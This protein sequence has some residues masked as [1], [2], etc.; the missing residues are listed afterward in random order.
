MRNFL[1]QLILSIFA[2]VKNGALQY[3]TPWEKLA[4]FIALCFLSSL[5]FGLLG[6]SMA[7]PLFGVDVYNYNDLTN[8]GDKDSIRTVKMLNFLFHIGT[9]ILPSIL[10]A[11]LGAFE[12]SDYL[13]T[14]KPPQRTSILIILFTRF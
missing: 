4:L 2:I 13:L 6:A 9:F 12:P 5:L 3:L 8:L 11:K 1:F 7:N 14:K 10:F